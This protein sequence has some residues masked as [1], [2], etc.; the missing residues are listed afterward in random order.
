MSG[1][2]WQL[3]ADK[4][5]TTAPLPL[6]PLPPPHT[7]TTHQHMCGVPVQLRLPYGS[8]LACRPHRVAHLCGAAP[9]Q[10]EAHPPQEEKGV[11]GGIAAT[12]I[13]VVVVSCG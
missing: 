3:K 13:V 9:H 10:V 1:G 2:T 4:P 7:S 12:I 5:F 11:L 6:F 8:A